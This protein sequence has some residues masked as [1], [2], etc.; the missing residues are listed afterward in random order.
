MH[1]ILADI[2]IFAPNRNQNRSVSEETRQKR[3][4]KTVKDPGKN[5]SW[6]IS[7]IVSYLDVM[8]HKLANK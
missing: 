2:F 1:Q 6:S 8:Y 3:R 7:P 5:L 4:P